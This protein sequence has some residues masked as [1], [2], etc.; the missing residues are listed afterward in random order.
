MYLEIKISLIRFKRSA[1][2]IISVSPC[3]LYPY[4]FSIE[5]YH[6]NLIANNRNSP[7]LFNN[8]YVDLYSDNKVL[9]VCI[10][11]KY[12]P[13]CIYNLK[14][15]PFRNI[16]LISIFIDEK[17]TKNIYFDKSMIFK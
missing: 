2:M 10:N 12:L 8:C 15:E 3:V 17:N 9:F 11:V 6:V 16:L 5:R 4:Q 7:N 1:H 14:L 13:C